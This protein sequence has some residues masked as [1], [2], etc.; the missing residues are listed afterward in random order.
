MHNAYATAQICDVIAI[1]LHDVFLK[2]AD[3]TGCREQ[4]AIAQLEKR[5]LTGAGRTGQK[6]KGPR[7]QLQRHIAQKLASAVV[8]GHVFKLDHGTALYIP[9]PCSCLMGEE[10]ATPHFK[11]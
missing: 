1:H 7:L 3:L 11:S 6:M 8:I 10:G 9:L 4:R 5:G 2:Q